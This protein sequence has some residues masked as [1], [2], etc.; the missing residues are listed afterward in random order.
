[1]KTAP[2]YALIVVTILTWD[3]VSVCLREQ[4]LLILTIRRKESRSWELYPSEN[5]PRRVRVR[6]AVILV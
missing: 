6:G 5:I 3:P 4:A 1:V 2:G